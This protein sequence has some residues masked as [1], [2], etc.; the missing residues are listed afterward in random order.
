MARVREPA[1]I[2]HREHVV[3]CND[4]CRPVSAGEK[5]NRRAAAGLDFPLFVKVSRRHVVN[6]DPVVSD[7]PAQLV[8]RC[9]KTSQPVQPVSGRER[10]GRERDPPMT[11]IPKV[12]SH[13]SH[14]GFVVERH[15]FGD[16]VHR[17]VGQEEGDPDSSRT[18]GIHRRVGCLCD[19]EGVAD[20]ADAP[21]EHR[22]RVLGCLCSGKSRPCA[23]WKKPARLPS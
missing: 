10:C 7:T 16:Q 5:D 4:C 2:A 11:E 23:R 9:S 20:T 3:Y 13:L 19:R 14:P 8:E 6:K 15:G 17:V 21:I 1:R 22:Q 12:M 18:G